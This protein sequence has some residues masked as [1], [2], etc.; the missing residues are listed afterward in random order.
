MKRL[1]KYMAAAAAVLT[2]TA[3]TVWAQSPMKAEV[4]F[5]FSA[6]GK[7]VAPG[8]YRVGIV[9]GNTSSVVLRVDNVNTR[10][11]SLMLPKSSGNASPKWMASGV[12]RIAFDCSTGACIL[13]QVW[14]GEGYAYQ[15]HGPKTKGGEMLLTEIV[16]KPDKAD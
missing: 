4:P 2:M 14:F 16:M 10:R 12:P 13:T 1:T 15:F 5:A 8:T 9:P 6:G 7:V 3:G 11:G